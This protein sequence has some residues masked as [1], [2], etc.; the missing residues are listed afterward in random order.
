MLKSKPAVYIKIEFNRPLTDEEYKQISI[1]SITVKAYN[2]DKNKYKTAKF[3]PTKD[4][5]ILF[6]RPED[7]YIKYFIYSELKPI[8]KSQIKETEISWIEY[9]T[10]KI[11]GITDKNLKP[12]SI[13]EICITTL[14]KMISNELIAYTVFNCESRGY[15]CNTENFEIEINNGGIPLSVE[16]TA[17]KQTLKN[18]KVIKYNNTRKE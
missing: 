14:P 6:G 3:K 10:I 8:T 12:T 15:I 17:R 7:E 18:F 4:D 9:G 11:S 2:N 13:N 16:Y 1:E 5:S